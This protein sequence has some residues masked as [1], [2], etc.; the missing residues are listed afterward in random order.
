VKKYLV[1]LVILLFSISC[2]AASISLKTDR[3]SV[4][5]GEQFA[6]VLKYAEE[7]G[8]EVKTISR[9]SF[10]GFEIVNQSESTGSSTSWINGKISSTKTRTVSFYLRALKEGSYLIEPAI[11]HLKNGKKIKVQVKMIGDTGRTSLQTEKA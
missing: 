1:Q 11:I 2:F 5:V 10:S 4:A 8:D 9:P 6:V 7:S 3:D